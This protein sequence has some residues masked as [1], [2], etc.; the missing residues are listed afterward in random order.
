[1]SLED[2]IATSSNATSS[3]SE[4]NTRHVS[5]N[6]M[7]EVCLVKS[8]SSLSSSSSSTTDSDSNEKDIAKIDASELWWTSYDYKN[9]RRKCRS[10]ARRLMSLSFF[11]SSASEGASCCSNDCNDID[12]NHNTNS[13]DNNDDNDDCTFR[14]LERMMDG[15]HCKALVHRT[16]HAVRK[17][18]ARHLLDGVE[19]ED[20]DLAIAQVYGAHCIKSMARARRLGR[21]DAIEARAALKSDWDDDADST[22]TTSTAASSLS[23]CPSDNGNDSESS[24][25]NETDSNTEH[26]TM[27]EP[28]MCS[29][30]PTPVNPDTDCIDNEN[31]NDND[32]NVATSAVSDKA[33]SCSIRRK[34][35]GRISFRS[36]FRFSIT[37]VINRRRRPHA[38]I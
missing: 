9:N 18:Q 23:G 28:P 31:D 33:K 35:M 12:S 4:C 27:N 8:V 17:E 5:F 11:D 20:S 36:N 34:P 21:L 1:M 14:G 16:I 25:V 30:T 2:S 26:D 19:G 10:M 32:N 6:S 37:N 24:P 3:I 29:V 13:I 38:W 22:S 15:G 7:A